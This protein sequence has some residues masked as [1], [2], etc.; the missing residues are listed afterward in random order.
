MVAQTEQRMVSIEI[1]ADDYQ[2]L[3][4]TV[5]LLYEGEDAAAEKV[6]VMLGPAV[7]WILRDLEGQMQM[8]LLAPQNTS[9]L[10]S[11]EVR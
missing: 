3:R 4:R 6:S 5:R 8:A 7:M 2:A 9:L 11:T 1:T 10:G